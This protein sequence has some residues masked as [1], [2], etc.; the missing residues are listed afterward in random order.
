MSLPKLPQR[1]DYAELLKDPSV[2]RL[3]RYKT[4]NSKR[5]YLRVLRR[6]LAFTVTALPQVR[7]RVT[8]RVWQPDSSG[9]VVESR[10]EITDP[11]GIVAWA[12][13]QKDSTDIGEL[14]ERFGEIESETGRQS[15]MSIIATLLK[16]NGASVPSIGADRTVL[17]NFHRGFT[18]EELLTLLS[19]LDEP[20]LKLYAMFSKD[21]GFRSQD[22]L[23]LHYHH[24][25]KDLEAGEKYVHIYLEPSYYNRR[26][27][28]GMSFIG[29][30][31]IPLL[32]QHLASLD[33]SKD[34]KLFTMS[35]SSVQ[36]SLRL[37]RNKAGL[38]R[39]LQPTH[40][41]RKF[42]E[43]CLD[44]VGM[45]THK[46]LQLEGHSQ[47]VRVHY[48]DREV[49]EL[50]LLYERAY[51]F[52][53]LSEEGAQDKAVKDLKS[54]VDSLTQQLAE[55]TQHIEAL[56]EEIAKKQ[57]PSGLAEELARMRERLEKLE[58]EQRKK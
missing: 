11:A 21:C 30:N 50:R 20:V 4:E 44:R 36:G 51:Q 2:Q 54:T 33:L 26:K 35:S 1:N 57:V 38:D 43:A 58:K 46:K 34:P 55:K 47:G 13:S 14:I 12:K 10:I 17:K 31:T 53:D 45:D 41:I 40:G 3:L 16:R 8:V 29:P 22:V 5:N 7:E 49:S 25:K 23:S 42:Y 39:L 6:F 32:K 18:R 15:S 37:A 56:K 27:A 48:T 28:S 52:L 19:Y 24:V 9:K